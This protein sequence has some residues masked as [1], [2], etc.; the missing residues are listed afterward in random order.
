MDSHSFPLIVLITCT[1][2]FFI[3]VEYLCIELNRVFSI[4]HMT[5]IN[6]KIIKLK[7]IGYIFDD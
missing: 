6:K 3:H 7:F 1:I 4:K 5:N 2:F